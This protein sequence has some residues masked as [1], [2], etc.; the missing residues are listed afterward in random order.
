[1]T[2]YNFDSETVGAAPASPWTVV[3]SGS[4]TVLVANDQYHSTPNSVKC[5]AGA[6]EYA[7]ANH[8]S[9][10]SATGERRLTFYF[11]VSTIDT[12]KFGNFYLSDSGGTSEIEIVTY[13]NGSGV[14]KLALYDN[15]PGTYTDILTITESTWYRVDVIYNQTTHKFYIKVD[16]TRYPTAPTYYDYNNGNDVVNVVLGAL[17]SGGAI[18]V[19]IDDVD[20]TS[21]V[22]VPDPPTAL[23]VDAS[24]DRHVVLSWTKPVYEGASSVTGYKVYYG[25]TTAPTTLLATVTAPTVS[26][27]H[28]G[29]VNGTLYYYRVKATNG[30]GDSAY[31]TETS[32]TPDCNAPRGLVAN[33]LLQTLTLYHKLG[34]GDDGL[35][36]YN[37]ARTIYGNVELTNQRIKNAKGE[38]IVATTKILVDGSVDIDETD[39]VTFSTGETALVLKVASKPAPDTTIWLR[40]AYT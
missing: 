18:D 34:I 26:Y 4:A 31:C 5:A 29:G 22:D 1:M 25:T 37:T 36:T 8:P 15:S 10:L 14:K 19:W 40:E 21:A 12:T 2:S 20:E 28:S 9:L 27:C 39:K 16:G 13:K 30:S 17:G 38:V 35:P 7:Y 3:K 32:S 33:H 23:T 11:R 24:G 6:G